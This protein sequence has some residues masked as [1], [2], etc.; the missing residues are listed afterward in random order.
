MIIWA[1]TVGLNLIL[2]LLLLY[3]GHLLKYRILFLAV[4]F[5]IVAA[6]I[7]HR[8]YLL[9]GT[10][11]TAY[12][13][14]YNL[15]NLGEM[16]FALGIIW[17]GFVWQ[18]RALRIPQEGQLALL[19]AYFLLRKAQLP[20][21]AHLIYEVFRYTNVAMVAWWCYIFFPEVNDER[22]TFR[23]EEA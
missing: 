4:V 2:S 15:K 3:R 14:S 11:S 18:N 1:I 12:L 20:H 19:L 10:N 23:R 13:F 21:M 16:A 17:E 5:E 6:M 8:I 9:Y 22:R 7:L